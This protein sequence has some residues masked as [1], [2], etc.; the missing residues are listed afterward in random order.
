MS[1]VTDPYQAPKSELDVNE[2]MGIIR[3]LK[4]QQSMIGGILGA[5][6]GTMP[7]IVF[8]SLGGAGVYP[9]MLWV[10]PGFIAGMSIKFCGRPF[11]VWYRLVPAMVCGCV[12]GGMFYLSEATPFMYLFAC[13]NVLCALVLSRRK[14][15][16]DQE[17][18]LYVYRLGRLSQ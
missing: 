17:K 8:L 16:P 12:V 15:R 9:V 5:I 13:L 6:I 10:L 11:E 18:A 2:Q 1:I 4:K 14:M 3:T 7:G